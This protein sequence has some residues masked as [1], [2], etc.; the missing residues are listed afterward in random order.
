METVAAFNAAARQDGGRW[1]TIGL[2]P[3][4]SDEARPLVR[5]PF[6]GVPIRPGL[7]FS[8]YGLAVDAELRVAM[9]G[10]G[11]FENVF[12]AGMIMAA[13]VLPSGYLAGLAVGLSAT[14]GRFAGKAAARYSLNGS[15]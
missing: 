13:N 10:G 14:F 3:A 7:T 9:Q 12:A 15:D 11:T 5:P 1:R 8:H 4:K 6:A 2:D